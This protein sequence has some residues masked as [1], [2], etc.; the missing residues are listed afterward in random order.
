MTG[1]SKEQGKIKVENLKFDCNN[2]ILSIE[3]NLHDLLIL[4]SLVPVAFS[5]ASPEDGGC[6]EAGQC[7]ESFLLGG[8]FVGYEYDCLD[9]CNSIK[10][11]NNDII[12]T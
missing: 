1:L 6:F 5:S 8:D 3:L 9:S 4:F 7:R 2:I 11:V 10:V 12:L